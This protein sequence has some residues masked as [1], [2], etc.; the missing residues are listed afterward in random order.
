MPYLLHII[1][2]ITIPTVVMT[3]INLYKKP[4]L[5]DHKKRCFLGLTSFALALLHPHLWLLFS[6]V[7]SIPFD[8]MWGSI[9]SSEILSVLY[10]LTSIILAVISVI[11]I[12][13]NSSTLCGRA[14]AITSILLSL[15]IIGAWVYL[16][17]RIFSY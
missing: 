14:Y 16:F 6:W 5:E 2:W 3:V 4:R 15:V 8:N 1:Y 13:K 11:R 7:T 9:G 17:F 10:S 12:S